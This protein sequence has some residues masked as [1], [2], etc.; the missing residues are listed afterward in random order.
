MRGMGAID[1]LGV[2]D[3]VSYLSECVL[4]GRLYDLGRFPGLLPGEGQVQGELF[5]ICDE[6]VLRVLDR[7][8]AFDPNDPEGSLFVRKRAKLVQPEADAW[9]YYYNREPRTASLLTSGDWRAHAPV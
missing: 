2:G 6:R 8:E 7:F 1:E 9:I 4:A 3:G 5:A